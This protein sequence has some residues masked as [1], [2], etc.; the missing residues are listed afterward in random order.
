MAGSEAHEG[1][2]SVSQQDQRVK[3]RI[4]TDF[5]RTYRA[6]WFKKL[7]SVIKGKQ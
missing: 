3:V 6:I 7:Y 1:F 4:K 5:G 2:R